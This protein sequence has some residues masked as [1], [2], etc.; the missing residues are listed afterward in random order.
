MTR[1]RVGVVPITSGGKQ[2]LRIAFC[3]VPEGDIP[4][5]VDSVFKA[6]AE[7]GGE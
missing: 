2:S 5:L 1:Y 4:R 3:S 6:A 7:A